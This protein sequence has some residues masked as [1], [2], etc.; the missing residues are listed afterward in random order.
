MGRTL[1]LR[2][3]A[4]STNDV[5]WDA[6]AAGAPDG[7]TVI[8]DAQTQ[9]RGRSGRSWRMAPGKGLA[10]SLAL[11]EGCERRTTRALPLVAGLA[12]ARALEGLGVA[13]ELKWPND[14][15]LR[16]RKVA[17]ILCESRRIASGAEAV[18]IGV[19]VN[20]AEDERDF[21]PELGGRAISLALAGSAASR[22]EVAASFLNALEPL[23][24]EHQEGEPGRRSAH[25]ECGTVLEAWKRRA[26]FWGKSVTVRSAAG[27]TTGIARGLDPDGGLVLEVDGGREV[28]VL[29]GD[30]VVAGGGAR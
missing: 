27:S 1:L 13:A 4:S 11:H 30:L 14:L 8:A 28:V 2:A 10:M 12:L 15:L 18:V 22:E 16:E 26:S 6:L 21:P 3:E 29:A 17:G 24:T 9:G 19:G 25:L 5:A 7:T 20:V 23:W